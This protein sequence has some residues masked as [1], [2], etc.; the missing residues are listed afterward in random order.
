M[1]FYDNSWMKVDIFEVCYSIPTDLSELKTK[2]VTKYSSLENYYELFFKFPGNN[3]FHYNGDCCHIQNYTVGFHPHY[4]TRI[5]DL[6]I[7]EYYIE[8]YRD[9]A[10][11]N[12]FFKCHDILATKA[13][14]YDCESYYSEICTLFEKS[15][16]LWN[17]KKTGYYADIVSIFYKILSTLQKRNSPSYIPS[18]KYD[19]ISSS[20]EYLDKHYLDPNLSCSDLSAIS[21]ISNTYYTKI[22]MEKFGVTPK[23]YIV[24]RKLEHAR[25]LLHGTLLSVS[26]ISDISGYTN[27]YSFSR[28]FKNHFGISPENYRN[29]LK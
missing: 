14:Y 27:L 11:I 16:N 29:S 22:F 24:T 5:L 25:E 19:M 9:S 23:K 15:H 6:P 21:N 1:A 12:I 10:S 8:T 20:I 28:A 7:N 4:A 18:F 3:I 26:E 13:E 2:K 17:S